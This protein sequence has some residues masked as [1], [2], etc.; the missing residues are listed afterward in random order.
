MD[1]LEQFSG[2]VKHGGYI[3]PVT[4]QPGV[5]WWVSVVF[6]L[7]LCVLAG[8]PYLVFGLLITRLNWIEKPAGALRT[9]FLWV[10]LTE[11]IPSM[12]PVFPVHALNQQA[13][14]LQIVHWGGTPTLHILLVWS[15]G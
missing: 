9:A 5:P 6:W 3:P 11:W 14:W 1:V 2:L 10:G 8:I 12:A 15:I 4:H 13:V 7:S